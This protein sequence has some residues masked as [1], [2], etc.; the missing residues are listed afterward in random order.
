[1][2]IDSTIDE[3]EYGYK[4]LM[5]SRF[6][7]SVMLELLGRWK[8]SHGQIVDLG[9]GSMTEHAFANNASRR[10]DLGIAA[11]YNNEDGHRGGWE[12]TSDI[13]NDVCFVG[14]DE[15]KIYVI[16]ID[17]SADHVMFGFE[18]PR[19]F[20]IALSFKLERLFLV[21][22]QFDLVPLVE[23]YNSISLDGIQGGN[24]ASDMYN[25]FIK[26]GEYADN[27]VNYVVTL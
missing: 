9:E 6:F 14:T 4:I 16:G 3:E 5:R 22:K 21:D 12:I 26:S 10:L 17:N 18:I 13:I 8:V 2:L 23:G 20:Y 24:A 1:M 19:S 15:G 27:V 25:E 7:W 11:F